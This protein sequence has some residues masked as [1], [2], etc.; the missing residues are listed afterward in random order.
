LAV[1]GVSI[2]EPESIP[3]R[4]AGAINGAIFGAIAGGLAAA[5]EYL[6]RK[7]LTAPPIAIAMALGFIVGQATENT[8]NF[9]GSQFYEQSVAPRVTQELMARKLDEMPIYQ[10]MQRASATE[11]QRLRAEVARRVA[12]GASDLEIENYTESFTASFRRSHAEDALA[13]PPE[14]LGQLMQTAWDILDFLHIR[15]VRLCSQYVLE[16][17]GAPNIRALVRETNFSKLVERNAVATLDT[18]AAGI[19]HKRYY[20]PLDERDI[21]AAVRGL[22]AHGWSKQMVAALT[23]PALLRSL[24]PEMICR[25]QR[26]WLATITSLP[27][28]TRSRWLREVLGP[29][30]RS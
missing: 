12:N 11:Y 28:P 3:Y 4:V 25:I 24:P 13:A 16:G 17:Y 14:V 19:R 2:G 20:Q 8:I 1:I 15:D 18:I 9:F 27:E 5:L 7:R 10:A 30:L 22:E 29:P 6:I 26:E 21:Q 23:D